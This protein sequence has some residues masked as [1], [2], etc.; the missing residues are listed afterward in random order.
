MIGLL[1]RILGQAKYY[2]LNTIEIYSKNLYLNFKYLSNIDRDVA[3]APVLKSNAYGHGLVQIASL[4]DNL[5]CPFFCVDSIYEAYE[6][7]KIKIKTPILIMG[8][9]DPENL[10]V[11]KLPFSY[12]VFDLDFAKALN[13]YQP[14]AKIHIFLDTG[15]NR[16]GLTLKDLASFLPELKKL[17]RIE[18]KGLMSHL[19]SSTK[20]DP[21]PQKQLQL[22][23]QAISL[24]KDLGIEYKWKHIAASGGLINGFTKGTNLARIGRAIYGI[25][26]TGDTKGVVKPVLVLKSKIIQVKKIKKGTKVGYDRTFSSKKDMTIGILPIGYNDGVDRRLSNIG[27]VKVGD[28]FCPI[29]G[30]ISMN[31]TTIDISEITDPQLRQEVI[32]FTANSSDKN[33]LVNSAKLCQTIAHDLVVRLNSS[34]RREVL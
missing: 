16:E 13:N 30:R 19:A 24:S 5:G 3:I 23:N 25:D 8:Y 1:K 10:K 2:P 9:I 15:L 11:K 20:N 28:K 21:Y 26:P 6:L 14:G 12:T 17:K 33:S 22:F 32:V 27:F 4:L 34:F 31:I 7:L 29:I 18:I